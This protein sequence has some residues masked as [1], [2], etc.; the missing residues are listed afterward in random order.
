MSL[1]QQIVEDIIAQISLIN[2]ANPWLTSIGQN[3]FWERAQYIE[4]DRDCTVVST[5]KEIIPIN[6]AFEHQLQVT[7]ECYIFGLDEMAQNKMAIGAT[8]AAVE[9]DLLRA[10][11]ALRSGVAHIASISAVEPIEVE[12]TGK[13]AIKVPVIFIFTY[14]TN[15]WEN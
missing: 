8:G 2:G 1:T 12:V 14:R 15:R 5:K 7:V 4:Y 9:T 6:L 3:V 13:V 11:G 10:I